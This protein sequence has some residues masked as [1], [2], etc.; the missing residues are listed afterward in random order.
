MTSILFLREASYCK[1]FRCI[2]LRYKKYFV[3]FFLDFL[4]LEWIL[5]IFKKKMT[6]IAYI[7]LSWRTQENVNDKCLKSLDSD[8]PSKSDMVIG[9]KHCWNLNDS[10]FTIFIDPC[11]DNRRWKNFSD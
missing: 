5:N 8:D 6:F 2:Y 7:F 4:N 3:N 9:P 1:I 10:T 11:E